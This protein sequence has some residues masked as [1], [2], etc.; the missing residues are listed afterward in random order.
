MRL[1]R[2]K[3][4]WIFWLI[5]VFAWFAPA[6]TVR[7]EAQP[8][9]NAV[10]YLIDQIP[11]VRSDG[12]YP[13]C[14]SEV[15]NNINRNFNGEP[16]QDCGWDFFM[17]H[18]SGFIDIPEHTTIEL[19][20]AADDGGTVNI[21]GT[22]FGTWDLKGCSWSAIVSP[23]LEPGPNPIDGWFF[24]AGGGTC[25]ML[26]WKIDDGYWEI[27]PDS[28]FTTDYVAP[29]TTT[30]STTPQPEPPP[31]TTQVETTTST[32]PPPTVPETTIPESSTTTQSPTTLPQETTTTSSSS[33]TV[34]PTTLPPSPPPGTT[35]TTTEVVAE[36]VPVPTAPP[37]TEAEEPTT[38]TEVEVPE[39]T[40]IPDTTQTTEPVVETT[41]PEVPE[42]YPDTTEVVDTTQ[43]EPPIEDLPTPE[44][45]ATP[46]TAEE[47][48]E[49]VIA[50]VEDLTTIEEITDELLEEVL[51]V[52]ESEN[53]TEEQ[54]QEIIDAV[55]ETDITSDQA[56]EL[57]TSAAVIQ[58]VTAEQATEIFAT[59][60]T[61]E[62]TEE[63]AAAIV[64][65]VQDAPTEVREAFEEE[66]NV[67][68]GGF[69]EYVPTGS[70]IS[71]AQRR[72][73]IAATGVLFVVPL[74]VPT[75]SSAPSGNSRNKG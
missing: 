63:E 36:P 19:M 35:T 52:L 48:T 26:A 16:F 74:P 14:G 5:A 22:E 45:L 9:L 6:T 29:T 33:T 55:L 59:I 30:S 32:T 28:A 11:P 49:E 4:S 13:T 7:A 18:Y 31:Q 53:I 23:T 42:T 20:V 40:T 68:E 25:Y 56:T 64:D 47:V 10:G 24:E 51:D 58:N 61:D 75:S 69:D 41:E 60:N 1:A 2:H 54:V 34:P 71:V 15:E 21:A 46:P 73:V 66:I 62:I 65:A 50:V 57:A 37:T 8:G 70:S 39:E 44:E 43:P 72:A 38:T 17:V 67:F 3:G 27:V 12:V